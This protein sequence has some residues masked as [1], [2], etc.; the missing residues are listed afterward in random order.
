MGYRSSNAAYAYDMQPEPGFSVQNGSLAPAPEPSA[1]PELNVVTGQAREADQETSPAFRHC[2]KVFA[3]LAAIFVAVGMARV[4]LAGATSSIMNANAE[5]TS[6]LEEAQ[7]E[8]ADLEVMYSVYG[9]STR[10]REL[11]ESYGMVAAEGGVT[12]DFTEYVE[13]EDT[14][15]DVSTAASAASA[16]E[17]SDASEPDDV[18]TIVEDSAQ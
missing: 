1:R 5:L 15:E 13:A 14:A 6:E 12:L 4:A 10:I 17:V 2:I 9:S 8:S 3:V 7:D 11:A 18:A 16:D